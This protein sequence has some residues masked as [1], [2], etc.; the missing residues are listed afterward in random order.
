[1]DPHLWSYRQRISLEHLT[2]TL[3][4]KKMKEKHPILHDFLQ[5]VCIL[6]ECMP[7]HAAH[8]ALIVCV[9]IEL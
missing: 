9:V 7:M 2:Q 4:D 8:V 1:M 5:M 3:Q 6:L